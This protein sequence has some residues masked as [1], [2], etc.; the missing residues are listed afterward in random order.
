MHQHYFINLL[1]SFSLIR[2]GKIHTKFE[3]MV[4][5]K[6]A[7]F[8]HTLFSGLALKTYADD[9]LDIDLPTVDHTLPSI[10]GLEKLASPFKF[11]VTQFAEAQERAEEVLREKC[12]KNGGEFAYDLQT[13]SFGT[14]S[15]RLFVNYYC[16]LNIILCVTERKAR[17]HRMCSKL[18]QCHTNFT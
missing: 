11:N 7:Y 5:V 17:S 18:I 12:T 4:C 3:I 13:V 16:K 15:R 14:S 8:L 1:C 9:D 6:N 10:P 2:T